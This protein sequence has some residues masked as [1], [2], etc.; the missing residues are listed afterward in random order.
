MWI[1]CVYLFLNFPDQS[2][3]IHTKW[4]CTIHMH[5][6]NNQNESI[7][8]IKTVNISIFFERCGLIYNCINGWCIQV[9]ITRWRA[10][11]NSYA[12]TVQLW[13]HNFRKIIIQCWNIT[14]NL[15]GQVNVITRGIQFV[16]PAWCILGPIS[17]IYQ[18]IQCLYI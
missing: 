9:F 13:D 5:E 2:L 15:W 11:F 18:R 12:H 7:F 6:L 1:C 8:Y 3:F 4:Q 10:F 17:K 14:L 16:Y